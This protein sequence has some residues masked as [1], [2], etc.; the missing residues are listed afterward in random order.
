MKTDLPKSSNYFN[1]DKSFNLDGYMADVVKAF[2]MSIQQS[3]LGGPLSAAMFGLIGDAIQEME[4]KRGEP[5]S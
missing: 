1:E 4:T 3:L 5:L 2:T